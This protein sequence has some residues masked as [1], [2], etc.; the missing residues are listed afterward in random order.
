MASLS[1]FKNLLLNSL[2]NETYIGFGNPESDVLFIGQEVAVSSSKRQRTYVEITDNRQQWCDIYSIMNPIKTPSCSGV[3]FS[4][5]GVRY[6]NEQLQHSRANS[7]P[8]F[9]N[10]DYEFS[11]IHGYRSADPFQ[12][13][14]SPLIHSPRRESRYTSICGQGN[15]WYN[16]QE[17][18]SSLGLL[19]PL[20]LNAYDP[21]FA[22][23]FM[24]D[25]SA[26]GAATTNGTNSQTTQ[27]SVNYRVNN[28]LS[29][30][31]FQS[32]DIVFIST[33]AYVRKYCGGNTIPN[34]FPRSQIFIINQLSRL[35]V[36]Y[37]NKIINTYK[38]AKSPCLIRI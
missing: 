37:L 32:F 9:S 20:T 12:H 2:M 25:L 23:C 34:L 17:V 7:T 5:G 27:S 3:K 1:G 16:Y 31:Y 24:T 10:I 8:W 38:T 4:N 13:Q 6:F 22:S 33:K 30:P 18:L 36:A 11:P 28:L 35:S 19:I 14:Y 15:T 21:L 29:D 26:L